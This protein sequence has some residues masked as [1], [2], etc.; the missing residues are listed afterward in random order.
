[1][2]DTSVIIALPAIR[3]CLP[4]SLPTRRPLRLSVGSRPRC[5]LSARKRRARAFDAL[6]A[7]TALSQG[8][9][10]FTANPDDFE[11]IPGLD[12]VVVAT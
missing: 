10:V 3:A 9:P 8:L 1:M 4:K 6:I 12:V 2:H 11:G 7:A 5:G